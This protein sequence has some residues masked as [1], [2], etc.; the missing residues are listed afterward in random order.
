MGKL[1]VARR[2]GFA[3]FVIV[4]ANSCGVGS[5]ILRHASRRQHPTQRVR[6]QAHIHSKAKYN[7]THQHPNLLFGYF[8]ET[9]QSSYP[10]ITSSLKHRLFVHSGVHNQAVSFGYWYAFRFVP[11][12]ATTCN[13]CVQTQL[14]PTHGS[15]RHSQLDVNYPNLCPSFPDSLSS[16]PP[17]FITN[18]IISKRSFCVPDSWIS[19]LTCS[20]I[21]AIFNTCLI[22]IAYQIHITK[23]LHQADTG[24]KF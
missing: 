2:Q 20:I 19:K 17:Q 5:T 10:K 16:P 24:S 6:Q 3:A 7:V 8:G 22:H 12:S 1:Q 4:T 14:S 9:L 18:S 21:A 11:Y 23:H 15:T 13:P